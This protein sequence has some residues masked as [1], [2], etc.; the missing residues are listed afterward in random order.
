VATSAG[1]NEQERAGT[2]L[3]EAPDVLRQLLG[4]AALQVTRNA[5]GSLRELSDDV[6]GRTGRR[7]LAGRQALQ[8]RRYRPDGLRQPLGLHLSLAANSSRVSPSR[9][10]AC[11]FASVATVAAWSLAVPATSLAAWLAVSATLAA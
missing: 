3:S 7:V 1:P 8:L 2:P 9:S 5:I 6:G 11:V 4:A 10:R